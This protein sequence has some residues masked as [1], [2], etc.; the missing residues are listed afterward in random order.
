MY[1]IGVD[2]HKQ[3][4]VMSVL[5]DV[6]PEIKFDRVDNRR[7]AV[8]RFLEGFEPFQAVIEAGYSS[9][10]MADLL[11]EL[12]GEVKMANPK[13]LKAIAQ[14]RIKTDKR[15]ARTLAKYLRSGDIPEVWQRGEEN[16]RAQ[17]VMRLRAFRVA[18]RTELK[19]KIRALLAQQ[20]EEIRLEVER[21]KDAL[22]GAK[23]LEFLGGL[24]LDELDQMI[25]ED[26]LESY[27][28]SEAHVRKTDGIVEK[29]YEEL[30]D[31]R[32]IDTVPGF[33][34]T[35]SVVVAVEI[36]DID[37][38][39]SA[40]PSSSLRRSDPVDALLRGRI[41]HGEITKEGNPWLRWAVLE[42]VFP[43]TQSV[44]GDP[45]SVCPAGQSEELEHRQGGCG[46]PAPSDHL[47]RSQGE[48]ELYQGNEDFVGSLETPLTDPGGRVPLG[49]LGADTERYTA[50]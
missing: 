30:E 47:S 40:G 32:R 5:G 19:N 15:D 43:A 36:G 38:F 21:R 37:R 8:R 4:S 2:H 6:G 18:K 22:F 10:V 29:L 26:Y 3:W 42:A 27:H 34:T 23:G 1:F 46:S 7:E 25:L 28:E 9:Y 16:R 35:L 49:G 31:A 39:E 44:V 12:G 50:L 45:R 13:G 11:R 17:R 41:H 48:E 20:K 14:A 24:A 33:A